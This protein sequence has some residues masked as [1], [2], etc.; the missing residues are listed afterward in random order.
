[1][2]HTDEGPINVCAWYRPRDSSLTSQ[3][4]WDGLETFRKE[5]ERLSQG[6]RGVLAMGDLNIHHRSWLRLSSRGD[7]AMGKHLEETVALTGLK[8]LV[9]EEGRKFIRLSND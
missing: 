5:L 1:M 8:Q 9:K 6:V 7:T 3:V 2:T 4:H